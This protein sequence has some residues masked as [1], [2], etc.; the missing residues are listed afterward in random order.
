MAL[1]QTPIDG[2]NALRVVPDYIPAFVGTRC[3]V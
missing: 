1:I 2:A 3:T